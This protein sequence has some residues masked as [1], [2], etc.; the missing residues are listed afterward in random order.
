MKE[1]K[2]RV[3]MELEVPKRPITIL[4]LSIFH[5]PTSFVAREAKEVL[6]IQELGDHG[7][8][9]A[10]LIYLNPFVGQMLL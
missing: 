4:T 10:F 2:V 6:S 8:E 1:N 3:T 5:G 7:I 9:M